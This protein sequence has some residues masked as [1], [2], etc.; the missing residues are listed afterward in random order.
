MCMRVEICM[1]Y[2]RRWFP[3]LPVERQVKAAFLWSWGSFFRY[4]I[5][6]C[7]KGMQQMQWFPLTLFSLHRHLLV[8][9]RK[10][11]QHNFP[12]SH[13]I[14][15]EVHTVLFSSFRRSVPSCYTPPTLS[16]YFL[17][18]LLWLTFKVRHEER[19]KITSFRA[20]RVVFISSLIVMPDC[21]NV[22]W[23]CECESVCLCFGYVFPLKVY[24]TFFIEAALS[25]WAVK[26]NQNQ[27]RVKVHRHNTSI[28]CLFVC[29]SLYDVCE[30]QMPTLCVW[31]LLWRK[32]RAG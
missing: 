1:M 6:F 19:K 22:L 15:T 23:V 31:V 14:H 7:Y 20:N 27:N 4:K 8:S 11:W 2:V 17:L 16:L 24:F 29:I 30:C 18:V 28:V 10:L 13:T 32:S 5:A 12:F 26:S 9:H 21:G 25:E 3:L